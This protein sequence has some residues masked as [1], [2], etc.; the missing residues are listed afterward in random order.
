VILNS[1]YQQVAT[2]R[3][4]WGYAS[5]QHEFQITPQNTALVTE[6]RQVP[7][8]LSAIGGPAHGKV[9]DDVLEELA[10]RAAGHAFEVASAYAGYD[11]TGGARC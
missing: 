1:S 9:N 7:A 3:P 8:T 11:V 6:F 10:N 5:D 4:G 2:V